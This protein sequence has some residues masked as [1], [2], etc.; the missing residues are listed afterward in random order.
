MGAGRLGTVL[1]LALHRA[2][3]PVVG[4]ASRARESAERLAAR[5]PDCVAAT[6][7]ELASR[8]E[9]I[10]L[11]VPDDAITIVDAE[12]PWTGSHLAVHCSGARPAA[13]LQAAARAGARVAGFHPLQSFAGPEIGLRNLSG[14]TFGIEADDSTW[15]FLARI[16]VDLGAVP[17]RISQEQRAR[18]HAASALVSNG[19]VGLVAVAAHL[20]EALG[21]E[22]PEAVR[23]FLPLL[24]GT[25]RNIR[26][27]GIPNA[28]TGPIVRG[29]V[30]T[31]RSHVEALSEVP[32][33]LQVYRAL[34]GRLIDLA[35]ERGT[36]S[37]E[38]AA[39]L[40]AILA[41]TSAEGDRP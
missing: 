28:L 37:V 16:A 8:A 10:F 20:W 21:V 11:T 34:A 6:P 30:G 25:L 4:C 15:P 31:V 12:V 9:V 26:A 32:E 3:Y 7:A 29:D 24:E 13:A 41:N 35:R 22:R 38:Q 18:Y 40:R 33:D 5:I 39:D 36:I 27:L 17:L 14:S 2:G 23:A 1:G 19:T